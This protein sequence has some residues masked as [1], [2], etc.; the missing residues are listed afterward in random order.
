MH[1][2]TS[3]SGRQTWCKQT[4]PLGGKANALC[5]AETVH[6]LATYPKKGME[7]LGPGIQDT[8]GRYSNVSLTLTR[9]HAVNLTLNLFLNPTYS[10][11][12]YCS[13][14]SLA[15]FAL[16]TLAYYV[17][18]VI[19][20][21]KGWKTFCRERHLTQTCILRQ[22]IHK[23]SLLLVYPGLIKYCKT[24]YS[25]CMHTLVGHECKCLIISS[26]L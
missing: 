23:N 18:Y 6:S 16:A 26:I 4:P 8:C 25:C 17:N 3:S 14:T 19:Y 10:A 13:V 24:Y 5:K 11:L 22:I 9:F 7:N 12:F 2:I 15:G 21:P 20:E 1:L